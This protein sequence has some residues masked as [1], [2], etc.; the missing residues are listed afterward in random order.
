VDAT[1]DDA[2]MGL[3]ICG[4]CTVVIIADEMS[5]NMSF[6]DWRDATPD[7]MREWSE[8]KLYL[9]MELGGSQYEPRARAE[10][11]RRQIESLNAA[12]AM[13]HEEVSNLT[14]SSTVLRT[15][16]AK[17]VE[18]TTRVHTEVAILSSSSD[19]FRKSYKNSQ[20]SNMGTYLSD[21][22]RCRCANRDRDLEGLP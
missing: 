5:E 19:R 13:V 17:L 9:C 20:E 1:R 8:T 15:L 14:Q 16:T 21:R 18:E 4:R 2:F 3:K 10:L 7:K 22:S 12:T 11:G 6:G